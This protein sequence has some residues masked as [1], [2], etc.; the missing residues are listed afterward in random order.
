MK[1][2]LYIT[3]ILVSVLGYGQQEKGVPLSGN[4][5]GTRCNGSVGLCEVSQNPNGKAGSQTKL[6]AVK[7][8]DNSFQLVVNRV[9]LEPGE[10]LRIVGKAFSSLDRAAPPKFL[11]EEHFIV[12]EQTLQAIGLKAGYVIIRKGEYPM[13]FDDEKIYITFNLEKP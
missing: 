6:S 11:M 4:F 12:D 2:I 7:I 13:A 1:K 5:G 10:E 8:S 9:N 3:G